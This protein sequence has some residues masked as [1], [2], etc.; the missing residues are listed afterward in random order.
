[1]STYDVYAKYKK[2][3]K[4]EILVKYLKKWNSIE[5]LGL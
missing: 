3:K 1:M 4:T 2:N 5:Q